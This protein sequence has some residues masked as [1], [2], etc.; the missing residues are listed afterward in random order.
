MKRGEIQ[1]FVK[2]A[3]FRRP[4]AKK[5][6][7]DAPSPFALERQRIPHGDRNRRTDYRGRA[8][9]VVTH[10][11][12]MHRSAFAVSASAL[13][14]VQLGKESRQIPAF[15]DISCVTAIGGGNHVVRSESIAHA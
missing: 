13:S 14:A 8:E 15:G 9:D 1:T 5:G 7:Y 2:N 6:D 3:F 4:V 11:H 10:V 12:H